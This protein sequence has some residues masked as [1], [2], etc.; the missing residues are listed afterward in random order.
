M[1]NPNVDNNSSIKDDSCLV[2][3]RTVIN[4]NGS[5]I[6]KNVQTNNLFTIKTCFMYH[7]VNT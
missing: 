2:V 4:K 3:S 5:F 1:I 7:K 6:L